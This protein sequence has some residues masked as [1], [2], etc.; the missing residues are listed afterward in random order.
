MDLL[1]FSVDPVWGR[2]VVAAGAAGIV[3]D[4]ERRG[5]H[6]RQAG[7]GTQIN[8]DTLEDLVRMRAATDGRLL[9]RVNA[10][11]P[12][13]AREVAEA[14]AA[15]ADEVLLPMV[16]TPEEVDRT[17]D[18]V[19]G[20]CGLGILVETQ[21]AVDRVAELARRPLSRIYVGLNDLRIDRRSQELFRP[22]VDGTVDAVRAAVGT[23]FGV[24]GL[25]LPGG[26]FPVPG[27][28]LAAELVRLRTDFT[29][30]RRSFTADMAGRDPA[31][32][33]PR[34]LAALA[35]LSDADAA[36]AAERRAGFVAA[37]EGTAAVDGLR[38]AQPA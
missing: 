37:V 35:D 31:V 24:G 9:C 26:G 17:L 7:E 32:E 29:F 5:K 1:L 23:R 30:L 22:L 8:A 14:V 34:L 16:R 21:D 11:G 18:L 10:A 27:M 33:V 4:W 6:R 28:L 3:V 25:T 12:W 38:V 13:T 36:T 19:A 20:R 15:G 2:D